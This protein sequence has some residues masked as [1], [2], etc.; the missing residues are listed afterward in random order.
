VGEA[1]P[2]TWPSLGIAIPPLATPMP[3]MGEI[4]E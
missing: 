2:L 3:D 4:G 1:P